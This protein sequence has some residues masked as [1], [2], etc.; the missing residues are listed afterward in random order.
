M[1]PGDV[2]IVDFGLA[3]GS[4]AGL[5]RPAMVVTSGAVLERRPRTV[6]VVPISSSVEGNLPTEIPVDALETPSVGQ[7]HLLTVTNT[8]RITERTGV[9][10]GPEVLAQV[11]AAAS[12]LLDIG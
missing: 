12:D 3:V 2:V 7:A 8:E 1:R 5:R 10:V 6:H 11:R 4:A 9:N